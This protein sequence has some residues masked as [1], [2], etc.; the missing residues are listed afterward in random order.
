MST[1]VKIV[2]FVRR[3]SN[4]SSYQKSADGT[5][6]FCSQRCH[7]Q[8]LL[9]AAQNLR[10]LRDS[11]RITVRLSTE[12]VRRRSELL[13]LHR[14]SQWL[15]SKPE[16]PRRTVRKI[17]V[18]NQK[19]GTGKTTT[20]VNLAAGLA[21]AG[22]KTLLI[23]LDAQGNVTVSLGLSARQTIYHVLVGAHPA[24]C[25]VN[26]SENFDALVSNTSLAQAEFAW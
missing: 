3:P 9:S 15:S 5:F 23:D 22:Y 1:S 16:E 7:E 19:G 6:Y 14:V 26:V 2:L 11:F 18:L 17:A 25:V 8:H 21:E 10:R 20:S 4:C 13:L 24:D 12:S